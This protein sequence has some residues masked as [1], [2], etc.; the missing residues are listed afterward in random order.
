MSLLPSTRSRRNWSAKKLI[1]Q[2]ETYVSRHPMDSENTVTTAGVLRPK[3]SMHVVN[4]GQLVQRTPQGTYIIVD[5][6]KR[7]E[8]NS[9]KK[10]E[11]VLTPG[12]LRSKSLVHKINQGTVLDG[13]DRRHRLLDRENKVLADFG[14][15]AQQPIGRPLMPRNVAYF[16]QV[17][18]ALGSGW[19]TYASWTNTTG[20][21]VSL[22]STTWV[23]PPEPATQ[24]GQTIFLFNGIQNATMIYQPV[25][26]WGPSA[27]GGGNR[28]SVASWYADGQGGV[29]FHSNLVDVN[30][31]D[32]LVGVMTLTR[33]NNTPTGTTFDYNCFFQGI[34]GTALTIQNVQELTWCIET[35]EAYNIQR[36]SDY[37]A[38]NKT[39]MASI[40]L[41]TGAT[42]PNVVWT[43]TDGVTDC[44]Q[45]T[46]IFDEGI[47]S[48][49]EVDI[50]YSPS[51]FWTFGSGTIGPGESQ[52]WFFDWGGNGDV[53]PQ[54]I[55]A[56]PLNGGAE[57]AT[58]QI[59]E[60][61]DSSGHLTYLAMVEN[62]GSQTVAFQ[63]RG[64]GF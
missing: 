18:P 8:E 39:A 36:C 26:Q 31:G 1:T 42:S 50:W 52:E 40:N 49:G 19:I 11:F 15:I 54:L 7:N 33:Q 46:L 51:P 34:N 14:I 48:N 5:T 10:E 30:P 25:L 20:T 57:L 43:V 38:I 16:A 12:G 64:G 29:A 22:F 28:W 27:A 55:Q 17:I 62:K 53:G 60:S 2:N 61:L 47:T 6:S 41:Q 24:S 44:G 37:P 63:W 23:V 32:I 45:H 21:P 59:S 58:T 3:S 35:L 13:T 4:Q 56:E 9:S